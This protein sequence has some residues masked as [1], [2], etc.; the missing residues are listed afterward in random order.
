MTLKEIE[1]IPREYLLP[2]EIAPL[3]GCNPYSI[4]VQA[5][6]DIKNHTNSFGFRVTVIGSRVKIP[7]DPFLNYM[8]GQEV[9]K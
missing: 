1:A 3:L 2:T 7:K 5:R 9:P 4:N 6:E 8:R